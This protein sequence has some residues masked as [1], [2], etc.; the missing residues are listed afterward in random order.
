MERQN[1]VTKMSTMGSI[2]LYRDTTVSWGERPYMKCCTTNERSGMMWLLAGV[3]N[4][5]GIRTKIK[6]DDLYI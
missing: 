1:R 6:E 4:L 2:A 3:W 5:R